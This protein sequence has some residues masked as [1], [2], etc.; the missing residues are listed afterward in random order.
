MGIILN[1]GIIKTFLTLFSLLIISTGCGEYKGQVPNVYVN[2]YVS[3]SDPDFSTLQSPGNSVYVSGGVNG[4]L[5]YRVSYEEFA[6]FDRT[7]TYNVEDNCAIFTDGSGI[8]AVDS[9]CCNSKFLLLDGSVSEGPA[10]YPLKRY[11]TFYDQTTMM[12]HVYN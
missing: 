1:K 11:R 5:I 10:T 3:L 8:F 2:F 9:T 12:L 4:I 7:C 6:A